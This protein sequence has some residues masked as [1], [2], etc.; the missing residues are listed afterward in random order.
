M[1][2]GK[3][4]GISIRVHPAFILV[5]ALYTVLGLAA[6]ALLVFALILAHETAHLLTARAYGFKVIGLELFPFGG[7]AYIDD[8][9]EGRKIEESIM[10]LAGPALN[11]ILLFLAQALR[12]QGWWMNEWAEE[13]VRIN[14]WLAIFNLLPVLPLDGGRVLR[15]FIC[16]TF[17]FVRTTKFLARAGQFIGIFIALLGIIFWGQGKFT[18]GS[19]F[20]LILGAFFWFAGKKEISVARI[21]FLRQLT[22]K[23]AELLRKGLMRSKIIMARND[24]PV[25]RI[26]EELTPDRY[27]LISL[28]TEEFSLA[29]TL[30]ETEVL[31]GML[32]EGI[33]CPVGKL[34]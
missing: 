20:F 28:A 27:A 4:A 2:L 19:L 32:R 29:K 18:E 23:K 33:Y 26:V 14:F 16:D 31:E 1:E 30:T 21:T 22:Q 10:A 3:V 9:F 7:A 6:Q 8:A 34:V 15:A 24:T 25:I 11:G 13:F 5:F 17:G 12:W